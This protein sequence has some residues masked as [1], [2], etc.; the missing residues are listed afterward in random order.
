M[1][2]T[3]GPVGVLLTTVTLLVPSLALAADWK[4]LGDR[5]VTDRVESDTISV[6]AD[7]GRFTALRLGARGNAVR[8]L[9]VVVHFGNDEEQTIERN[10]LVRKGKRGPVLDLDGGRRVI[11]KVTF[12]YEAESVGRGG[13]TVSLWGRR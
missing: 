3:V 12:K 2:S 10:F 1:T 8:V 13:A 7:E 9:R 4:R 5:H 11:R 6:G